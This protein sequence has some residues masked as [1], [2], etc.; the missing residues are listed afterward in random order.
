MPFDIILYDAGVVVLFWWGKVRLTLGCAPYDVTYCIAIGV[1]V[2]GLICVLV[3]ACA[4][5]RTGTVLSP[6][7]TQAQTRDVVSASVGMQLQ[8]HGFASFWW[9]LPCLCMGTQGFTEG[10][11]TPRKR[12]ARKGRD[13]FFSTCIPEIS[14]Q[15]RDGLSVHVFSLPIYLPIAYWHAASNK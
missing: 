6:V 14:G 1:M 11:N 4:W 5:A 10:W 8:K 15:A 2:Y 12:G 9:I 3:W 7:G 13:P